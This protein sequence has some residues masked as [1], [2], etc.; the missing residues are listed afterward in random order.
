MILD[1]IRHW[2]FHYE[3]KR[4]LPQLNTTRQPEFISYKAA[5][6]FLILYESDWTEQNKALQHHVDTLIADGK[7]VTLCGYVQ[8]PKALSSTLPHSIMIDRGD[9]NPLLLKPLPKVINEVMNR[10]FDILINLAAPNCLPLR[11]MLLYANASMKCGTRNTDTELFDF[12]L[13][14]SNLETEQNSSEDHNNTEL[15]K[16]T[17]TNKS[18]M[19]Y[20][21]IIQFLKTMK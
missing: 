4:C 16:Q 7:R 17:S 12:I 1:N 19:V 5:Q 14:I 21:Q 2:F 10:H 3:M 8:K 15:Q 13:D 20:T 18:E 6:S 9:L 11:Y